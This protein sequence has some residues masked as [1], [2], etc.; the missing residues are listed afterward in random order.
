MNSFIHIK[1]SLKIQID[2]IRGLYYR[3]LLIRISK[4]KFG[5]IG[6]FIEPVL[7]ICIWLLLFGIRRRFYPVSGLDLVIFLTVGNI[8]FQLFTSISRKS[9]NAINANQ[10]LFNFT[11]VK[12]FDTI[13][14]RALIEI[15]TFGVLY[16]VIILGYFYFKNIIVVDNLP[17]I[18]ISYLLTSIFAIGLGLILMTAGCRYAYTEVVINVIYRPLYFLSG[19]FFSLST[20]PDW[21]KPWLAWNPILHS[22]ELSRKGFSDLYLLDPL[23]SLSYLFKVTLITLL[24]GLVVYLKNERLLLT[25]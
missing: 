14:A 4:L 6:I 20:L 10:A 12:P 15:N 25:K 21:L 2:V 1:K 19:S 18:L 13:C 16:L 5:L 17:L 7:L 23:I 24:L 22:I 9:I 11:R 8:V 3:E